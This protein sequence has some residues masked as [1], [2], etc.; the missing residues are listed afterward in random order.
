MVIFTDSAQGWYY[1]HINP[2]VSL[3]T[4]SAIYNIQADHPL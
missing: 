2:Y 1:E 4:T 3:E